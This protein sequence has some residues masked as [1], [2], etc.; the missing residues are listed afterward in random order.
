MFNSWFNKEEHD[1]LAYVLSE[2]K[3]ICSFHRF[4]R[5]WLYSTVFSIA[6]TNHFEGLH[7]TVDIVDLNKVVLKV[8]EYRKSIEEEKNKTGIFIQPKKMGD[9]HKKD[10]NRKNYRFLLGWKSREPII[11]D[12]KMEFNFL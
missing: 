3:K 4:R 11:M 5:K 7:D 10:G 6:T 2:F 1:R 9:L 12:S 8:K